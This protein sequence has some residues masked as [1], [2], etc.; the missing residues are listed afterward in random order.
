MD[1]RSTYYKVL[2]LVEELRRLYPDGEPILH[3]DV[4][5]AILSLFGYSDPRTLTKYFKILEEQDFLRKAPN[6]RPVRRVKRYS[7]RNPKSGK[8]IFY[9]NASDRYAWSSYVFGSRAPV[10]VERERIQNCRQL[11]TFLYTKQNEVSSPP[12]PLLKNFNEFSS[13][14][15]CVR[16]REITAVINRL[17]EKRLKNAS[18][19]RGLVRDRGRLELEDREKEKKERTTARTHILNTVIDEEDRLRAERYLKFLEE[20]I[21]KGSYDHEG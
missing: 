9:E 19:N 17:S 8:I 3:E 12:L 13:K 2:K 1:R 20:S 10:N 4:E 18:F 14:N 7:K 16:I 6:A 21:K 15:M 11:D 5:Y